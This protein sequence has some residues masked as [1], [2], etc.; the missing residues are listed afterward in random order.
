MVVMIG[1]LSLYIVPSI[2][3]SLSHSSREKIHS[4]VGVSLKGEAAKTSGGRQTVSLLRTM[5]RRKHHDKTEIPGYL[6]L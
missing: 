6:L 4:S 3:E 2:E 5:D 1:D